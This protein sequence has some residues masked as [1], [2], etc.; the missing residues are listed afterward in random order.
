MVGWLLVRYTALETLV[1]DYEEDTADVRS[2]AEQAQ[3]QMEEMMEMQPQP[4]R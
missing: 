2:S 4:Q 1:A 3:R